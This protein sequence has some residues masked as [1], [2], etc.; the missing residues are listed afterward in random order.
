MH[1]TT[2][3]ARGPATTR[4][5]SSAPNSAF[6]AI[7]DSGETP[8]GVVAARLDNASEND[9][10]VEVSRQSDRSHQGVYA[11]TSKTTG[12]SRFVGQSDKGMSA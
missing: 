9:L 1:E 10:D 3:P 4:T 5:M 6:S 12:I 7:F 2:S 8:T 11:T